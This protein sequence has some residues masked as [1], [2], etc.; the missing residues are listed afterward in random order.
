VTD[1]PIAVYP[2]S[3][4]LWDAKNRTWVGEPGFPPQLIERWLDAGAALVG[5]CCRVGPAQIH[6]IA[7]VVHPRRQTPSVGSTA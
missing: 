1:K 6:R 4:E 2:N 5:G 7:S 3:G